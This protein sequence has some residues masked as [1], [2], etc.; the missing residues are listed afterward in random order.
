MKIQHT[1]AALVLTL[2]S[3]LALAA[4][5]DAPQ[6]PTSSPDVVT[7]PTTPANS[8][9]AAKLSPNAQKALKQHQAAVQN[10]TA[11]N[12]NPSTKPGTMTQT[13]S[14]STQGY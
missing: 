10:G 14:G 7:S 12:M 1:L 13:P 2:S 4:T 9:N 11:Q 6:P 8:G 5:T 3:G